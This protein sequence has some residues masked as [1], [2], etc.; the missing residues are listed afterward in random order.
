MITQDQTDEVRDYLLSKN[1]AIDLLIEIEDHFISQVEHLMTIKSKKFNSAFDEAKLS[2]SEEFEMVKKNNGNLVT[3][4]E[5][6][7]VQKENTKL[8]YNSFIASIF[9][10]LACLS[11]TR[12]LDENIFSDFM[13]YFRL[14]F[15]SI[16][17]IYFF[18]KIE[19]YLIS[20]KLKKVK[21]SY[22]NSSPGWLF[23]FCY[24]IHFYNNVNETRLDKMYYFSY[25]LNKV[26]FA[27]WLLLLICLWFILFGLL[28][29][30]NFIKSV[31]KNLTF[32][33]KIIALNYKVS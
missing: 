18:T 27:N 26:G 5:K 20:L 29:Q 31:K 2:W 22:F 9:I 13:F 21:I 32:I 6:N 25:S 16:P 12:L 10:T 17:T 8:F 1:L 30:I 14:T 33:N 4:L 28:I 7:I 11:F 19:Y 15:L 23:I 24:G 3:I